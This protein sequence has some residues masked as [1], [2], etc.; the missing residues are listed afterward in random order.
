MATTT[1]AAPQIQREIP[2]E[3][4]DSAKYDKTDAGGMCHARI[5]TLSL[6]STLRVYPTGSIQRTFSQFIQEPPEPEPATHARIFL[7]QTPH[8]PL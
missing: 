2:C 3:T 7:P 1:A 5:W 8:I 4:N 6:V